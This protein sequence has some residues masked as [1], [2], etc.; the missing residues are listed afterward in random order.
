MA[1]QPTLADVLNDI[2]AITEQFQA[3][4][5]EAVKRKAQLKELTNSLTSRSVGIF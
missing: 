3:W 4:N 5:E 1:E 2:N